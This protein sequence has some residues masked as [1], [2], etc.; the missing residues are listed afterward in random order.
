MSEKARVVI[1]AR[2]PGRMISVDDFEI[3]NRDL[4][5]LGPDEVLVRN[6]VTSVDPYMRLALSDRPGFPATKPIGEA[7]LAYIPL[8]QRTVPE[9]VA[10]HAQHVVRG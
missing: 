3:I 10:L 9:F 7:I 4:P 1:L 5:D 6:L 2:R 8:G